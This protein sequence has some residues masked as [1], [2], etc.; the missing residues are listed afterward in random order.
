MQTLENQFDLSNSLP[1]LIQLNRGQALFFQALADKEQFWKQKAR[2]KWLADGDR[3]TKYFHASTMEKRSRLRISRIRTPAG[4]WLDD[5]AEIQQH[6]VDFF[7][8]LLT[9]E[10]TNDAPTVDRLLQPIQQ[11]VT[12]DDNNALL[13]PIDMSEVRQ[14]V[15]SLYPDSAP[16]NDGFHGCFYRECWDIISHDLLFAVHEFI[17]GVPVPRIISSTLMV[18]LPNPSTFADFRPISLAIHNC[19]LCGNWW[20]LA[21]LFC[22]SSVFFFLLLWP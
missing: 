5:E 2:V 12:L 18:L 19:P 4:Q 16:G 11:L 22:F 7:Q 15:F 3:N 8:A 17:A 9:Q 10:G 21:M 13:R 6:A 20:L 14:A 1:D